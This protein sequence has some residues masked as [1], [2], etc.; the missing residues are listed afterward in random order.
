MIT[1]FFVSY[2]YEI[3]GRK[4][5][6]S[7][8]FILTAVMFYLL[9]LTAPDLKMLILVR[10]LI[11]VTMSAPIA[12]PLIPDYIKAS[13]RGSAI[14]LSGVGLVLGEVFSMGILFN[15]TK[16]LTYQNAFTVAAALI[17]V[18]S[19]FFLVSIK[20]PDMDLIRKKSIKKFSVVNE[21]VTPKFDFDRNRKRSKS[22]DIALKI[23]MS[24]FGG[25]VSQESYNQLSTF[26]KVVQLTEI[27]MEAID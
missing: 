1:T 18:F 12:H 3:I 2:I 25:N 5:T 8:S 9:P 20:E 4:L 26:Q 13:S 21:E 16:Q 7:F 14:A 23:K 15:L 17:V 6:I 11:G 22:H 10:C 24:H 19:I 27:V